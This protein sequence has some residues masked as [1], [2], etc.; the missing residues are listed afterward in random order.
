M[1]TSVLTLLSAVIFAY[2]SYSSFRES[3]GVWFE[4][5][6]HDKGLPINIY[7]ALPVSVALC[8][9]SFALWRRN[10]SV[11]IL[12]FILSS[13]LKLIP[14]K[15]FICIYTPDCTEQGN[16]ISLFYLC[17]PVSLQYSVLD[18][19]YLYH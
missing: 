15:V 14:V 5:S 4:S 13:K 17:V 1:T 12:H 19:K 16:L 2:A 3:T 10:F 6:V 8:L 7:I 11:I 18:I 9:N